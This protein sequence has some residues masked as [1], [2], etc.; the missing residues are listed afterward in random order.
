MRAAPLWRADVVEPHFGWKPDGP[1]PYWEGVSI[2]L[3][4]R[5]EVMTETI[6]RSSVPDLDE[7]IR[8]VNRAESVSPFLLHAIADALHIP[9]ASRERL[10]RLIA[11]GAW[12]D[13]GL[14]MMEA[15]LPHWS[16]QRIAQDD[17]L[18]WCA[19]DASPAALW[20][21][22]DVDVSHPVMALAILKALLTALARGA[23]DRAFISP[24]PTNQ[25]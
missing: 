15:A 1:T 18:W 7:L 4:L 10:G 19:L 24:G 21:G 16:L 20:T 17:G 12:N 22:D 8:Q 2:S 6:D 14:A 23:A 5:E 9:P 3:P 25:R 11:V 13:A